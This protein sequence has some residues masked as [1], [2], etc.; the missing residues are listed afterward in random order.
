MSKQHTHFFNVSSLVIGLLEAVAVGLFAL[1]RIVAS[2]TQDLQELTEA[3]YSRNV[4]ARIHP[5]A[6]EAI[7][8]PDN[9]ALA[10]QTAQGAA[11]GTAVPAAMP[12]TGTELF[13]QT[14]TPPPAQGTAAAPKA[15]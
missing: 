9:S 6:R 10:I 5:L 7:A 2:R 1:A 4:D 3:D 14:R 12:K 13:E 8:G 15:R 11:A